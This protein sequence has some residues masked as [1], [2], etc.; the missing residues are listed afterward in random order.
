MTDKR[1]IDS[2]IDKYHLG[3]NIERIKWVSDNESLSA[4][5]INDSQNLVGQI[6]TKNFQFPVGEFGI[7]STSTLSKLLGILENEVIFDV[8]KEGN[9]PS[10]FIISDTSMDVSFNLA[11]PQVIPN[12]PTIN[13]M[14]GNVEIELDEEFTTKFIKAKDA[15]G[16]EVFYIST[17]EGFTSKEVVFTIGNNNT[18][19]VSFAIDI[20]EGGSD[21]E[22][23]N[24]PFN[25]DLVKEIF[26]HNKR[27]ELGFVQINPKGLMT[28][29]FKFGDLETNYYLVRN[30]NQ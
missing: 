11:D 19:S 26:K 14:E 29:A 21:I 18:N 25:S 28:F 4:K 10:K 5:F 30:Q 2:F 8:N 22:L 12:I 3:G 6:T 20:V 23:D 15:V 24:I 16:E 1:I 17:R 9:T 7:Y 27:F 13:K